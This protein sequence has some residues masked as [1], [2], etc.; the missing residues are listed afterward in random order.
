[1]QFHS[2]GGRVTLQ[3]FQYY[4]EK[5][6]KYARD[7]KKKRVPPV[8]ETIPVKQKLREVSPFLI[9]SSFF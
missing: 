5:I 3:C 4:Y 1:M 9:D 2:I 6:W 7:P 8:I